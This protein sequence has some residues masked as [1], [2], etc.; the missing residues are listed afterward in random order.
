MRKN[1]N[2][3]QCFTTPSTKT[4]NIPCLT[5]LI[6]K[7]R[8]TR[9]LR[10]NCSRM[11]V[12]EHF[13]VPAL[14][15]PGTKVVGRTL[16]NRVVFPCSHSCVLYGNVR[17]PVFTGRSRCSRCSRSKITPRPW[18]MGERDRLIPLSL[19]YRGQSRKSGNCRPLACVAFSSSGWPH[20]PFAPKRPPQPGRVQ[21]VPG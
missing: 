3:D 13:F 12:S 11:R 21:F 4:T 20:Y 6:S 14:F 15:S 7:T 2:L 17:S 9:D 8:G 16:L 1:H 18:L 10:D 5:R 19:A